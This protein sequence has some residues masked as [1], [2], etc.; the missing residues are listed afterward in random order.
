MVASALGLRP[1]IPE[2]PEALL[3]PVRRRVWTEEK[4]AVYT[5]VA[6]NGAFAVD[7]FLTYP[8][9]YDELAASA[10]RFVV[11]GRTVLVSCKEHL[12]AAK[13]A[14][15]PPRT[16]DLRDIADLSELLHA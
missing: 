11:E 8:Q 1:R 2:P 3:D 10:D 4:G 15:D 9:G 12:L 14:M 16:V 6:T 5:L 13:G 7:V